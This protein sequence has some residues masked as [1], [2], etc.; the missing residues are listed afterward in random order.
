MEDWILSLN[1]FVYCENDAITNVDKEGTSLVSFFVN[2]FRKCFP[3]NTDIVIYYYSK[4]SNKNMDKIAY[5][6][7]YTKSALYCSV[8]SANDLERS[9]RFF[10]T[11]KSCFVFARDMVRPDGFWNVGMV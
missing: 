10:A 6:N 9:L 4:K 5:Q 7:L 2:A 8:E 3:K 1:L 11:C